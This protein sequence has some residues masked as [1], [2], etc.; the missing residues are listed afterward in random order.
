M[1]ITNLYAIGDC[2]GLG[3]SLWFYG[4]LAN[5]PLHFPNMLKRHTMPILI[6]FAGPSFLNAGL[7]AENYL[8]GGT[9]VSMGQAEV[10]LQHTMILYDSSSLS[11]KLQKGLSQRVS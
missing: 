6:P 2:S 4:W 7:T 3:T 5:R 8:G 9:A 10:D 1:P 11:I